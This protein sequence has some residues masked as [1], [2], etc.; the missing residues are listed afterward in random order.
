MGLPVVGFDRLTAGRGEMRHRLLG[1]LPI[2]SR[3]GP[4]VTRSAAGR[5]AAEIAWVPAATLGPEVTWRAIDDSSAAAVLSLAG[6]LHEVTLTVSPSGALETV[7]IPRWASVDGGPW[8]THLFGAAVHEE[9]T[10][11]G[12]TVPTR[13]TAGY[14]FGSD[15]W[16]G[17]AFIRQV[18]DRATFP[19]PPVRPD[20]MSNVANRS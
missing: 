11:H 14:E 7:T 4:D 5:L 3:R 12:F 6:A 15:G 20:R 2:V 16:P 17:C 9:G 10:F 18:I 19:A 8:R 1:I 13:I